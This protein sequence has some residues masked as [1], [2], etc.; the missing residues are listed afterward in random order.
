VVFGSLAR[1][2][3]IPTVWVKTMNADW[4]RD[5]VRTSGPVRSWRGHVFL[6]VFV[7]GK[8]MLLNAT[9]L[10]LHEDYDP[11]QR[12]LPGDRYAYDK[13]GDPYSLVLSP[14]WELWKQQTAAY[15]RSFNV[16]L[17]PVP[18]GD[19]L[20]RAKVAVGAGQLAAP[21][22]VVADAPYY[23]WVS[24]RCAALGAP[25]DYSFNTD[26]DTQL[27]RA[28]GHT[29]VVAM[30]GERLV[31]PEKYWPEQTA[32]SVGDLRRRQSETG[33]GV[34]T[35]HRNDGTLVYVLY[36]RDPEALRRMVEEFPP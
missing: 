24:D 13:G 27:P 25:V 12:I 28:A 34:F 6:E 7:R 32:I 17:L 8:W 35:R 15:F 31:L 18:P 9:E 3:G 22:F 26:F 20:D 36:G 16:A 2:A 1:A 4:I 14:R 23:Q 19:R 10:T 21:V 33:R 11:R 29:L 30:V 5:F